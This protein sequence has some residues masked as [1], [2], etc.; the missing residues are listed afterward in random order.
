[1]MEKAEALAAEMDGFIYGSDEN[2]GT[3]T[4]YVSPVPFEVLNQVIDKG[5]GQPHL[6]AVADSMAAPNRLAA[7]LALAPVAGVIGAAVRFKRT[8]EQLSLKE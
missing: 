1:M 4:I 5:P 8:A 7:A 2:G 3:N 6:S